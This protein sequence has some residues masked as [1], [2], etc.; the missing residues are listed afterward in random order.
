MLMTDAVDRY[1]ELGLRLGRHIDGFVDA[2]FGPAGI[3]QRVT[4]EPVIAPAKLADDARRLLA[5]VE[6]GDLEPTRRHFL[7]AQVRGL[8]TT[9]RKLAGEPITYSD[10]VETSYGVRP[11]H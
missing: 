2:Y 6:A 1:L 9:A 5:D 8:H 10:E 11:Q 7:A 4:A 3:Q